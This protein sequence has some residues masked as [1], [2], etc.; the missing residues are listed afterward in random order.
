[1]RI[2]INQYGGSILAGSNFYFND[3]ALELVGALGVERSSLSFQT[4]FYDTDDNQTL[5]KHNE[6]YA[7]LTASLSTMF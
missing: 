4:L 1:M 7:Q 3:F 6:K 5:S 2:K